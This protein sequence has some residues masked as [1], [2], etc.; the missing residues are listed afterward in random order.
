MTYAVEIALAFNAVNERKSWSARPNSRSNTG[1]EVVH[2]NSTSSGLIALVYEVED[3]RF[4]VRFNKFHAAW[5]DYVRSISRSLH[6]V[7]STLK[8]AGLPFDAPDVERG[9]EIV[10][11][12]E[13]AGPNVATYARWPGMIVEDKPAPV[14]PVMPELKAKLAALPRIEL[15]EQ[16]VP[17]VD[18]V[19]ALATT[20]D[21]AERI[22]FETTKETLYGEEPSESLDPYDPEGETQE[23][24]K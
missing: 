1:K 8:A 11:T 7:L 5:G 22:A 4:Q 14:D 13:G 23:E 15:G 19:D 21:E 17:L 24:E 2:F 9:M 10:V 20:L 6:V 18:A 16:G 3:K 12:L